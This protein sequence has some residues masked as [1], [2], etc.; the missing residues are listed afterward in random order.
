MM[1]RMKV[2][3]VQMLV[4]R[5]KSINLQNAIERISEAAHHGA[6]LVILPV[7]RVS[8]PP[9]TTAWLLDRNASIRLTEPDILGNMLRGSQRVKPVGD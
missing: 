5:E 3:V 1:M 6:K 4:G 9:F 7:L 2:G 8:S